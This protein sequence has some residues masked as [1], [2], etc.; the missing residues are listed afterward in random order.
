[1]NECNRSTLMTTRNTFWLLL[2]LVPLVSNA[3]TTTSPKTTA[4]NTARAAH[5]K[6]EARGKNIRPEGIGLC[7]GFALPTDFD[8]Q[9]CTIAGPHRGAIHGPP[10]GDE[11]SLLSALSRC[12]K[13]ANCSGVTTPW[14]GGVPWHPVSA[15]RA[16]VTQGASYACTFLVSSCKR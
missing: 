12:L 3:C 6:P 15:K 14:N 7:S 16:F 10:L 1:M 5:E 8:T 4:P 13:E 9:G 11:G 2:A